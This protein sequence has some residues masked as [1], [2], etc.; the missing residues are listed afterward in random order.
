M[1]TA[2]GRV[3]RTAV[4]VGVLMLAALFALTGCAN[5]STTWFT[6][7][8]AWGHGYRQAVDSTSVPTYL[9][10][11]VELIDGDH[12]KLV[13]F[14][15]GTTRKDKDGSLCLDVSTSERYTGPA[16]W[17][18]RN[19]VTLTLKYANSSVVL[20]SVGARMQGEDWTT[21][22]FVECTSKAHWYLSMQCGIPGYGGPGQKEVPSDEPCPTGKP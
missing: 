18:N 5:T 4:A 7:P 15:Q 16:V 19:G 17:S 2:F 1:M 9:P 22:Q 12:A 6:T 21:V 11:E 20:S 10:T 13:D 8:I 3:P 14:P